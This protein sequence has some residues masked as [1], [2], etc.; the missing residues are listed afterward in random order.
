MK[1]LVLSGCQPHVLG[2]REAANAVSYH[3]VNELAASHS[4]K[5]SYLYQYR[6][7]LWPD[8]ALA[9]ECLDSLGVN[10]FLVGDSP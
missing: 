6:E 1:I 5:V 3:I 10:S 7:V 9:K 8:V 2:A 4:W